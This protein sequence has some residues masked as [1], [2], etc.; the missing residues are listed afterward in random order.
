MR[1][2]EAEPTSTNATNRF[3]NTHGNLVKALCISLFT[4]TTPAQATL[5]DYKEDGSDND[6]MET[7]LNDGYADR[8]K[9]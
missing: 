4:N 8:L 1:G 9:P 5:Q 6:F 3:L 7:E 2:E